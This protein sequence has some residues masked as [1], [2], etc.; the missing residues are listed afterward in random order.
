[1]QFVRERKEKKRKGQITL[2]CSFLRENFSLISVCVC[3][4]VCVCGVVP[5]GMLTLT[6]SIAA[7]SARL[8]DNTGTIISAAT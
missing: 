2:P 6:T 5:K 8:C 3:V 4:R 7:S 1:M